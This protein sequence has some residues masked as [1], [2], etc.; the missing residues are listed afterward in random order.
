[1]ERVIERE[2]ERERE[3]SNKLK[4]LSTLVKSMRRFPNVNRSLI[5]GGIIMI[6]IL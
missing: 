5:A 3:R 2:R 6:I 1:M 4:V